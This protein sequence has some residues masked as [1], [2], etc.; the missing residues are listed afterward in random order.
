[1]SR[2]ALKNK[3]FDYIN[4]VKKLYFKEQIDLGVW[5]FMSD[6]SMYDRFKELQKRYPRRTLY[7]FAKRDDNDD[8][9]CFENIGTETVHI[10][11]DFASEGWE[12]KKTFLTIDEFVLYV[13]KCNLDKEM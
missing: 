9:A 8:I 5:Y 2:I 7:P 13:K 1:M 3:I 11:H 12:Q 6:E 10:I 4:K